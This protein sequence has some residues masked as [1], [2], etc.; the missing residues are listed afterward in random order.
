VQRSE[1]NDAAQERRFKRRSFGSGSSL[2]WCSSS[3]DTEGYAQPSSGS[4]QSARATPPVTESDPVQLQSHEQEMAVNATEATSSRSRPRWSGSRELQS[5]LPVSPGVRSIPHVNPGHDI[6]L[7]IPD[8]HAPLTESN[9]C[10][11]RQPTLTTPISSSLQ[12]QAD[13]IQTIQSDV[14]ASQNVACEASE[15]ASRL[16]M[17]EQQQ[18]SRVYPIDRQI[19]PPRPIINPL[20][21]GRWR[22][23]HP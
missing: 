11:L 14:S 23:I 15:T 7:E 1:R 18:S 6:P 17:D 9:S 13:T 20:N 4:S 3:Q 10:L 5:F 19:D 12:D 22:W 16:S 21:E 8:H 2:T